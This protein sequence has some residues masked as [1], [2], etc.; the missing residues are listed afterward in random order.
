M[1]ISGLVTVV[2]RSW[3][4]P[5]SGLEVWLRQE[6]DDAEHVDVIQGLD[7]NQIPE[8]HPVV[9]DQLMHCRADDAIVA[10]VLHGF[11]EHLVAQQLI[12]R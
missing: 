1:G 4:T 6:E 12:D 5:S 7:R 2:M 3:H 10:L 11:Q 8:G 9:G